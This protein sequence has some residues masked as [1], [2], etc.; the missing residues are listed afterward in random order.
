MV[1]PPK[2]TPIPSDREL[3]IQR[4]GGGLVARISD[5][6]QFPVVGEDLPC[7]AARDV[8]ASRVGAV[9]QRSGVVGNSFRL[10]CS[11]SDDSD[12][13]VLSVGAVRPLTTA[14]PLGGAR[15]MDDCR[16]HADSKDNVLSVGAWAPMSR[17]GMCCVRF[18]DF[19]WVV[20]PYD[21]DMVLPGR[22]DDGCR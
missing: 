8:V 18:D 14:A 5:E 10:P 13:D 4:R 2:A 6:P 7:P 1:L 11:D 3:L 20:S 22:R 12:D 17:H 9:N 15:M 19:D 16:L 21:P